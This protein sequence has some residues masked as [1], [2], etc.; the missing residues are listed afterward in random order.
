M[1]SERDPA[2]IEKLARGEI[3][4][5]RKS[6]RP[7][8]GFDRRKERYEYAE[9]ERFSRSIKLY[10]AAIV[11]AA[12]VVTALVT[13]EPYLNPFE[14]KARAQEARA[15]IDIEFEAIHK[16]F[17]VNEGRIGNLEDHV[18][19]IDKNAAKSYRLQ[20]IREIRETRET[21]AELTPG[22][23][24]RRQLQAALDQSQTDLREVNQQLG[25]E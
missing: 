14:T 7:L 4:D 18:E 10:A 21:V 16:K 12:G 19:R 2:F 20:L 8:S 24:A 6:S 17:S 25:F 23:A 22:T 15:E 13:L 5:E 11:G 9:P 1:A 3:E